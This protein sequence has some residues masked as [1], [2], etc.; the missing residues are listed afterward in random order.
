MYSIH[1]KCIIYVL[2]TCYTSLCVELLVLQGSLMVK[3]T[4]KMYLVRILRVGSIKRLYIAR[5]PV[6]ASCV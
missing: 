2:G 5:E 4:I 3:D 1:D 6:E